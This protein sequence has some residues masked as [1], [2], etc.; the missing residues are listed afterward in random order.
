MALRRFHSFENLENAVGYKTKRF[1][2]YRNRLFEN[3][4][5][6]VGH[7]TNNVTVISFENLENAVRYK[8][9]LNIV[10]TA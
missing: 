2:Y 8:T 7:K 3:L 9:N 10:D 5:N 4:E 1:S 6:A